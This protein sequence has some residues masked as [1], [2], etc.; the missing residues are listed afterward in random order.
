MRS[1]TIMCHIL[2]S[3]RENKRLQ[4]ALKTQTCIVFDIFCRISFKTLMKRNLPILGARIFS[5]EGIEIHYSR[6]HDSYSYTGIWD[7]F[8]FTLEKV[9]RV[10]VFNVGP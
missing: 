1:V 10:Y 9:L 5:W 2:C 7:S 6:F 4:T 3:H 8:K